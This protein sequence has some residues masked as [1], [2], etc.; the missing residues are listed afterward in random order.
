L[1]L[2]FLTRQFLLGKKKEKIVKIQGKIATTALCKLHITFVQKTFLDSPKSC[3]P[4]K[5]SQGK[6][7]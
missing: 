5:K 7:N 1:V 4:R 6:N 2:D 3:N